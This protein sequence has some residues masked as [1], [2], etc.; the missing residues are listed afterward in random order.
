LE[1]KCESVDDNEFIKLSDL[2][3]TGI[4]YAS[5]ENDLEN[6]LPIVS[7]F[8]YFTGTQ[9]KMKRFIKK[10]S[11][12]MYLRLIKEA[13]VREGPNVVKSLKANGF[14]FTDDENIVFICKFIL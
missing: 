5:I 2:V 8:D 12:P 14:D 9:V 6:F 3:E 4:K 1:K 10:H 11:D 13:E 7:I